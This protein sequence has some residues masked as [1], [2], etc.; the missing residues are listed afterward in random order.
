MEPGERRRPNLGRLARC[1][2]PTH[3]H[4]VTYGAGVHDAK[5]GHIPESSTTRR[6]AI[7]TAAAWRVVFLNPIV[8]DLQCAIRQHTLAWPAAPAASSGA[9]ASAPPT[10]HRCAS[11]CVAAPATS[12]ATAWVYIPRRGGVATRGRGAIAAVGGQCV[13]GLLDVAEHVTPAIVRG[14]WVCS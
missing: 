3:E 10:R 12:G 13:R 2:T 11:R 8:H 14:G 7:I 1:H 4:T 5:T 9:A 6:A